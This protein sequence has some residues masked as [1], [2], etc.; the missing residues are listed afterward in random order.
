VNAHWPV[1]ALGEV[2]HVT[3]G[4]SPESKHY[5][6]VG[7][8]LPFYQGK[9]DFGDKFIC[10]PR[11]WTK[12]IT[13]EALDGDIL[14]SV[15]A[16]VGPINF[17]TSR[18]CIGRGL[19][20]IRASKAIDR[21]FLFYALLSMQEKISGTEG[22]VFASINKREIEALAV[23]VPP[24][25]QQRRI[26]GILDEAFAGLEAMRANA[27][28]NLQNACAIFEGYLQ[29]AFSDRGVEWSER[30]LGDQD[31]L[32]IVDGDRGPNYPKSGDFFDKGHCLFLN[33]KNVR[34]DG[35]EFDK[36]TFISAAKDAELR[37]GK[38]QRNDVVLTTRGTIGNIGLYSDN[39]EFDH[40]RIN[41]GMLISCLS[42]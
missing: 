19:A 8:G 15:R 13:K 42:A 12:N 28:K 41:S 22:A 30:K 39:V 33:T 18:I 20:G 6:E 29:A 7:D 26:V 38:L 40:I 1:K 11:I 17:A 36:T 21:E 3:A 2:C 16:P 27:E 4:Q 9:K 35:F 25:P 32:K 5:N 23:P 14:M 37:K 34:P 31:L 24:L 10:P